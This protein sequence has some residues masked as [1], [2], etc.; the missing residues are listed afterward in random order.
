M[1]TT[2]P[3]TPTYLRRYTDLPALLRLLTDRQLTLLDPKTWD[4]RNDSFFMSLYKERKRLKTVLGICFSQSPETYHHWRVFSNGS[5][6]V[7]IVF[8]RDP[9]LAALTK[10]AGVSTDAM[11]YLTL[12]KAK[13]MPL[14]IDRLPFLKRYG[15]KPENEFRAIFT[16][17][18]KELQAIDIPIT[19]DTVRSISLSPWMHASLSKATTAAI[20][21]I[22]GCERLKISR[23]TLVS[24]EQWKALGQAAT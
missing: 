23:S 21:K 13:E 22:D 3:K 11:T 8:N 16:S 7:C 15:F 6:G 2:T 18:N 12:K 24:N 14:Q 20:R 10:V 1:A 5:A 4:D 17:T 9:L 19:L